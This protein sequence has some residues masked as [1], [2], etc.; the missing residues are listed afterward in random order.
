M[1]RRGRFRRAGN[2]KPGDLYVF[3]DVV[4][5]VSEIQP[6]T[7]QRIVITSHDADGHLA[8]HWYGPQDR[9][10]VPDE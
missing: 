3:G 10:A 4:R 6:D 5:Q 7:H 8:R 9:V 1:S 2:L